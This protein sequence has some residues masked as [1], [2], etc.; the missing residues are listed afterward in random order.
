VAPQGASPIGRSLK[1]SGAGVV[2]PAETFRR[3]DHPVCA[4]AS[5]SASTPP[6]QAFQGGECHGGVH[7]HYERRFY[8]F[9]PDGQ[10][11]NLL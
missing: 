8:R 9:G 1:R 3:S 5:L 2:S 6:F 11:S 4:F 7:R 10:R